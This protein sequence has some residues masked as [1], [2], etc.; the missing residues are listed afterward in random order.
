MADG[1]NEDSPTVASVDVGGTFTDIIVFRGT[2]IVSAIKFPTDSIRPARGVFA[3]IEKTAYTSFTELIHATTLATNALLSRKLTDRRGTSL[4]TTEGF[5][6]V[7]EVARQNRSELYN[8]RFH[9]LP[10]LIPKSRRHEVESRRIRGG[11]RSARIRA[12]ALRR[13]IRQMERDGT[14]SVAVSLIDGYRQPQLER[15]I[16]GVLRPR[17]EFVSISSEVAPEPREYE[18]SSTTVVNALLMPLISRYVRQLQRGT[19]TIHFPEVSVM[20]SSGGLISANEVC[21]R[22]VQ[23]IESG[24]AAGVIAAGALA[25]AAGIENAISFDMG[26]TTAKAG[27]IRSGRIET[28]SDYEVGGVSHHGRQSKGSGYPIRFPFVDL[29]EVSA[30][31]GTIISRDPEG[32]LSIGPESA[33]SMPGPACYGRGGLR[34]TLTDATLV[35]GIL[36]RSLLGG[37][38]PLDPNAAWSSLKR[39]GPPVRVAE[40]A[41]RLAD[42]EMA[43]AI[44]LVTVERGLDPGAFC[45]IAF[46][47]AGPQYAARI[48]TELGV[49]SV[50]I[51]PRPGLFSAFGLLNSD[52]R[53]EAR[54]AFPDDLQKDF[55]ELE[56]SLYRDHGASK[57]ERYADCRYRGQGSELTVRVTGADR[58]R[59]ER[60]FERMHRAT[61]GFRLSHSVEVVVIR[62]FAVR[63]RGK[64][65]F[66]PGTRVKLEVGARKVTWSGETTR[67][68]TYNRG[69][70]DQHTKVRGPSCVDDYDSTIFVP[71]GWNGEAGPLGQFTMR[72]SGR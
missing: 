31:G 34:P 53:Y 42:L 45:L 43:R 39:L 30:G 36:G 12:S 13:A 19:R 44:R 40:A 9:R 72:E 14:V 16:A 15:R 7:L 22:P 32:G 52:W 49:T 66:R 23:V 71:P 28:T 69:G 8:P 6:D 58:H 11:V 29:V 38:M 4:L 59:I 37:G 41:L 48:A 51:P 57:F 24:P 61:F 25:R 64:P 56:G 33:G 60:S 5:R 62:V 63:G 27:T 70:L 67:A 50:V 3:A 47:G 20:A 55:V 68:P 2:S 18:R 26:G 65:R 35:H 54:R 1:A 21:R 10:P 17:F 46:G